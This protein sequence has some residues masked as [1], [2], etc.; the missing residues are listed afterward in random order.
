MKSE[1][2]GLGIASSKSHATMNN[3]RLSKSKAAVSTVSAL[4]RTW[5]EQI[6]E[7]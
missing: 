3:D 4:L 1:E 6:A 2:A 7:Y 5:I